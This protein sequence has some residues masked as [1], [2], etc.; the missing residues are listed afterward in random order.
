MN[1]KADIKEVLATV[2]ATFDAGGFQEDHIDQ[3][4]NSMHKALVQ[5]GLF[6]DEA[7]ALLNT[8]RLSYFQSAGLRLFFIVPPEWT[9]HYLPFQISV[10]AQI[11]RVMVGR[12]ELITPRHREILRQFT[13]IPLPITEPAAWSKCSALYR[14]LGRFRNALYASHKLSALFDVRCSTDSFH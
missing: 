12:I 14:Q 3:L 6:A 8:W 1:L 2:P 7:D 9:D 11:K 4:R 10:P 5:A 13:E